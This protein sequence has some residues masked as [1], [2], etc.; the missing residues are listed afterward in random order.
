MR[1]A[2]VILLLLGSTARADDL[3]KKVTACASPET[4]APLGAIDRVSTIPTRTNVVEVFGK[5]ARG[6]VVFEADACFVVPVAGKPAAFVKGTFGRDAV[7]AYALRA[8]GCGEVCATVVS[9]KR[10]D[11]TLA[12]VFALPR[13]CEDRIEL[14]RRTVFADRD[15]IEVGCWNSAGADPDRTDLLLD[16]GTGKLEVMLEVV[17]GVAWIQLDD[18][19]PRCRA[20]PPGGFRVVTTGTKPAI[21]VT[22]MA[23][24]EAA[25]AAKVEWH[26]GGCE[27]TVA[28]RRFALD[29]SGK[30][31]VATSAKPRVSLAKKLCTCR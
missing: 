4:L 5:T 15:S 6:Y 28:T 25:E 12:D 13:D 9:L 16:A 18:D 3:V 2:V 7:V 19:G 24:P 23:T 17:A 14:T 31:F 27:A 22:T 11:D 30:R 1:A 26:S 8:A 10:K 21:D 29:S 20:R